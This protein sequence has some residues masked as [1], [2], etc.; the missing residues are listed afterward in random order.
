MAHFWGS[1][2]PNL[3]F[4]GKNSKSIQP[5]DRRSIYNFTQLEA[6]K[7]DLSC[8]GHSTVTTFSITEQDYLAAAK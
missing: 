4:P 5:E 2:H 8:G 3:K 1:L 6:V 7:R